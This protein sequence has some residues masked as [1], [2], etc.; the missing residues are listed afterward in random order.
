MAKNWSLRVGDQTNSFSH[1]DFRSDKGSRAEVKV[2]DP[3][4]HFDDVWIKFS[5]QQFPGKSL[6]VS[7]LLA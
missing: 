5:Q 2:W 6:A 4:R 1:S 3:T 7:Q